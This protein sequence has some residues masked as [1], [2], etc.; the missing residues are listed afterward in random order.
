MKAA[1]EIFTGANV[2]EQ[3]RRKLNRGGSSRIMGAR[4]YDEMKRTMREA[5]VALHVESFEIKGSEDRASFL[6]H[7]DD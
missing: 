6:F 1:L 5:D 3:M 7:E 2:T 4:P